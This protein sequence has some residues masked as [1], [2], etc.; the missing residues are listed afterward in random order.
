MTK[1]PTIGRFPTVLKSGASFKQPASAANRAP[2]IR[3]VSGGRI[4]AQQLFFAFRLYQ[5]DR[6]L[7]PQGLTPSLVARRFSAPSSRGFSRPRDCRGLRLPGQRRRTARSGFRS[8]GL[9]L[10]CP[11]SRAARPVLWRRDRF[12]HS[13]IPNNG[14]RARVERA[15]VPGAFFFLRQISR[16]RFR[17]CATKRGTA[18]VYGARRQRR[19]E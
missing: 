1:C 12:F 6:G 3:G 11:R 14:G 15:G 18:R 17:P 7:P 4:A 8:G 5:H 10:A 16:V 13:G 19:R 9:P 2:R